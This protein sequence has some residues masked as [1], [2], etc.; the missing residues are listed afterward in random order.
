[1][2]MNVRPVIRHTCVA[3]CGTSTCLY[4]CTV[5]VQVPVKTINNFL[6]ICIFFLNKPFSIQQQCV[7]HMYIVCMSFLN[8]TCTL[9]H[10]IPHTFVAMPFPHGAHNSHCSFSPNPKHTCQDSH[11]LVLPIHIDCCPTNKVV[12][13]YIRVH[14]I[15]ACFWVFSPCLR[16]LVFLHTTNHQ[17][18]HCIFWHLYHI[19][20]SQYSSMWVHGNENA[21]LLIYRFPGMSL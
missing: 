11:Q 3:T 17:L 15:F 2:Y 13:K 12:V 8:T 5:P 1:M 10:P 20:T 14:Q 4:S 7:V 16:I 6:N 19:D 18:M 21:R 9:R